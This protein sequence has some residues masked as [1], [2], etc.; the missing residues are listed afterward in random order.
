MNY[1]LESLPNLWLKNRNHKF[2]NCL[3]YQRGNTSY[4]FFRK[5]IYQTMYYSSEITIFDTR[6]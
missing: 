6:S 4:N 3:L 1:I 5:Q 2:Y